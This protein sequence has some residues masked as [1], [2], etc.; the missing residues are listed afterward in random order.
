MK[1]KLQ[2]ML[3]QEKSIVDYYITQVV[4]DP[5]LTVAMV[6][7]NLLQ[8]LLRDLPEDSEQLEI[9]VEL[10]RYKH[11]P[12]KVISWLKRI[13]DHEGGYWDD[14]V[15]GPTKWG[16]SQR[17]YPDL[18]IPSL[19][20]VEAEQIYR[21]DYL[22]PLQAERYQDG[23][24]YQMLDFAVHSGQS[25]AVENLQKALG[26]KPDGDIGPITIGAITAHTESDMAMLVIA[27]RLQFMTELKN[28]PEN[29]RGWTRRMVKNLLHAVDD[30]D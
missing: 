14:P 26:V 21:R 13:V 3:D 23:I 17:S 24:I 28:W 12:E 4:T 16:I 30:T 9:S 20:V 19:T 2:I 8:Q 18:D 29:S 27:A 5:P 25:N 22:T 11:S 6:R 7:V 10:N 1:D 15:G